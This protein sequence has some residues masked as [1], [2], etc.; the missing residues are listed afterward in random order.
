MGTT[1]TIAENFKQ[2]V[3]E[4]KV[5]RPIIIACDF[6]GVLH[7]GTFPEIGKPNTQLIAYLKNCRKCGIKVILYTMREG[8]L[9]DR[10]L[11]FCKLWDLEFDAVN[12]N[13]P[14]MQEIYKNN[15]RKI[16]FDY[17]IDDRIALCGFGRRLPDLKKY[18]M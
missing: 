18:G 5:H 4:G 14:E 2:G 6:D 7:Y 17:L 11:E 12:D 13:L 9:L 16:Y 8:D 1:G 10:A 15:P 3:H